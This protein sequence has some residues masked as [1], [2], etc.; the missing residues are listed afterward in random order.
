MANMTPPIRHTDDDIAQALQ[1]ADF[2]I[3]ETARSLDYN[4]TTVYKRIQKSP[5]L[6]EFCEEQGRNITKEWVLS[7][8]NPKAVIR[9][10]LL[11]GSLTAAAMVMTYTTRHN[12]THTGSTPATV[13]HHLTALGVDICGIPS[14]FLHVREGR[15]MP[16]YQLSQDA[17]HRVQKRATN[18][19]TAIHDPQ[20]TMLRGV[21][22]QLTLEQGESNPSCVAKGQKNHAPEPNE[23]NRPSTARPMP[24]I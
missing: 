8:N 1:T 17:W 14:A 2:D 18:M 4:L 21:I 12:E 16:H 19:K 10:Y 9:E 3:S 20:R 24:S 11:S 13:R 15:N 23:Q 6:Q 5:Y 22:R 7:L